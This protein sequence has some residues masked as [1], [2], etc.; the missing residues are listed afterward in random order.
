MP[1]A[2]LKDVLVPAMNNGTAV[3][4][5]VVLG[6]EDARAF[7]EAAEEIAARSF[8]KQVLDAGRILH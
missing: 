4:G 5:F 3:A 6:W 7:V 8:C 2:N 1:I